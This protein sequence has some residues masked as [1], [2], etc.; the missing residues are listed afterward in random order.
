[1]K[2]TNK[3][4]FKR[5]RLRLEHFDYADESYIIFGTICVLHG[6][7][8]NTPGLAREVIQSLLWS[9]RKG[10]FKLYCYCLMPDHLHI[11]FSPGPIAWTLS[12][13]IRAF[14]RFTARKSW[15]YG[16]HG[17]LWQKSWY[18]HVARKSEDLIAICEY[19]LN[20]P[21]RWGLV[22]KAEDWPYSWVID[23]LPV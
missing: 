20:N 23:V 1:M 6:E 5:K 8:F 4:P 15:D 10:R 18:D 16:F 12:R 22:E 21:V 13:G 9:E 7:P 14:K 19:I 17:S 2:N 11:L 3:L